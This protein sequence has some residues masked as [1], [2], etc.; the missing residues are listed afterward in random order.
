LNGPSPRMRAEGLALRSFVL[1][2]LAKYG[3]GFLREAPGTFIFDEQVSR[4]AGKGDGRQMDSAPPLGVKE[5]ALVDADCASPDPVGYQA[6]RDKT[7]IARSAAIQNQ[8]NCRQIGESCRYRHREASS[9]GA[10]INGAQVARDIRHPVWRPRKIALI[11]RSIRPTSPG[12][13]STG[14][15]AVRAG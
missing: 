6:L 12:S 14:V 8:V 3:T 1:K 11:K 9:S 4:K 7:G 15:R 10:E 2:A 5:S 13:R